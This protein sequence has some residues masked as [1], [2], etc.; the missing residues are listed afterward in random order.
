MTEQGEDIPVHCGAL[1]GLDATGYCRAK[2][3]A[4]MRRYR[5]LVFNVLTGN[6][7]NHLKN[8]SFLVGAGGINVVPAYDL[9][10]TAVYDTKAFGNDNAKWPNTPLAFSLG[11][12]TTC[13]DVTRDLSSRRPRRS[14]WLK[15]PQYVS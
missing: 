11:D 6:G 3:A 9:L 4:R 5:W 2:A 14:G 13:A 1:A 8:I 7:D 10:C 12:A 15:G